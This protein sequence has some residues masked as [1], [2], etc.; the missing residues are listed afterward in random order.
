MSI[1]SVLILAFLCGALISECQLNVRAVAWAAVVCLATVPFV[2]S[3]SQ[4]ILARVIGVTVAMVLLI[5]IG[6]FADMV[7]E[8]ITAKKR[9]Q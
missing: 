6:Y 1:L 9:G 3:Q 2:A 8:A 4:E 7:L 5:E